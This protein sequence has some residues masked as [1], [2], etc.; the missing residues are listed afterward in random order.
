M[1]VPPKALVFDFGN[2]FAHFDYLRACE[3]FAAPL[4]ISG[5]L[6]L[7]TARARGLTPILMQYERHEDLSSEEFSEAVIELMGLSLS[8]SFARRLGRHFPAQRARR[9]PLVA[10]SQGF[11]DTG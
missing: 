6:F 4:G 7:E 3:R 8:H 10:E 9:R 11:R 1:P 2:V 5:A